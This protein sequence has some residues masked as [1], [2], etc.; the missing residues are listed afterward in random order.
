VHSLLRVAGTEARLELQ[1][2]NGACV[3]RIHALDDDDDAADE[4]A[5]G[6]GDDSEFLSGRFVAGRQPCSDDALGAGGVPLGD[7]HWSNTRQVL[8][9]LKT[10]PAGLATGAAPPPPQAVL[11]FTL[12]FN[13]YSSTAVAAAECKDDAA[14]CIPSDVRVHVRG[15]ASIGFVSERY[16]LPE[17]DGDV[18][19]A[20]AIVEHSAAD[21]R[22]LALVNRRDMEGAATLK[23]ASIDSL[24][25]LLHT[26]AKQPCYRNGCC[27]RL[28]QIIERSRR[29]LENIKAG[30]QAQAV[31]MEMRHEIYFRGAMSDN[32]MED[33]ADSEDGRYSDDGIDDFGAAR[34]GPHFGSRAH[35]PTPFY[36][37]VDSDDG[38]TL[39]GIQPVFRAQPSTPPLVALHEP[40]WLVPD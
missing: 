4:A 38:S 11:N 22:V 25:R 27:L 28:A 40:Q 13:R 33:R 9:N 17:V 8:L 39:G 23:E 31:A 32:G 5:D 29:S 14:E 7:L 10:A 3:T 1:G 20:A 19:C 36:S 30:K 2:V 26:L 12:S 24:S 35:S 21:A 6:G 15:S 16:E 37:D 18:A 34:G